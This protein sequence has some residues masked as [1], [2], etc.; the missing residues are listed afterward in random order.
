[1]SMTV[2][3]TGLKYG[4]C[5]RIENRHPTSDSLLR[6][7]DFVFSFKMSLQSNLCWLAVITGQ[8]SRLYPE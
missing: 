7:P 1:M 5:K 4:K 3:R 6:I 2:F 8:L